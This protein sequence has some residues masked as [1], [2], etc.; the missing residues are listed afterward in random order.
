MFDPA[1]KADSK[2]TAA[3]RRKRPL[4]A[5]GYARAVFK[6]WLTNGRTRLPAG[7]TV[8]IR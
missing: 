6:H 4:P 1:P 2:G 5:N 8:H 3:L 7:L